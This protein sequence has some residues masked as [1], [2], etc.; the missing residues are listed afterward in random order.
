MSLKSELDDLM[1]RYETIKD[2]IADAKAMKKQAKTRIA[3]IDEELDKLTKGK[4]VTEII[5]KLEKEIE[6]RKQAVNDKII[7]LEN[8]VESHKSGEGEDIP[9]IDDILEG[10]EF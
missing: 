7:E 8:V 6:I 4:D 10:D 2:R 9:T 1:K 3:E 5:I